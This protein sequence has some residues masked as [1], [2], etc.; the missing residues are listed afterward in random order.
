MM[1]NSSLENFSS[2]VNPMTKNL[3]SFRSD[4]AVY[5]GIVGT[6]NPLDYDVAHS[7]VLG[8]VK[9]LLESS[10]LEIFGRDN[11]CIV[12]GGAKGIDTIAENVAQQLGIEFR[13]FAPKS[14]TWEHFKERNLKIANMCNRVVSFVNPLVSQKC[15]HCENARKDNNHER[16]GG[17]YTGRMNGNYE[18]V[19][20]EK[21]SE[22]V[23]S[24]VMTNSTTGKDIFVFGSNRRGIHGAGAAK[25]ARE[26]H[27]AV[28]GKGE[29]LH[30]TSYAIPTKSDPYHSLK[31]SEVE[32]HVKKFIEF[33]K[34]NPQLTFQL[35]PIGCG[36]AGF[37]PREIA[38]M[39]ASA[40]SNVKI[41]Q[42]FASILKKM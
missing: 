23:K 32:A 9:R 22:F 5:I 26:N 4:S 3:S 13:K 27:G 18:V 7:V 38:P 11:L 1:S 2:I 20:I 33:A 8:Y 24:Q 35:T 42:V 36:L 30:G 31:T 6:S 25:F 17:C 34:A 29:G 40:P 10:S 15:Y 41:P 14:Q 16:S 37:S 19:V 28:L 39:F 21:P 12:S